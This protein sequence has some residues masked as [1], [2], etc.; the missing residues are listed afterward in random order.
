MSNTLHSRVNAALRHIKDKD[1]KRSSVTIEILDD[2]V[3]V[4]GFVPS[5]AI[6]DLIR[7]TIV[8]VLKTDEFL[9]NMVTIN[10]S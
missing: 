4:T 1:F 7:T 3:I 2:T 10:L 6:K 8:A 9:N 5:F